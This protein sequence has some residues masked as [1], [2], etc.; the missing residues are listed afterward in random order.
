MIYKLENNRPLSVVKGTVLCSDEMTHVTALGY[1]SYPKR[2]LRADPYLKNKDGPLRGV[3]QPTLT[4]LVAES[5]CKHCFPRIMGMQQVLK[6]L[7]QTGPE[8]MAISL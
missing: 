7:A 5:Q 8:L 3:L 4:P 2:V 6:P 1:L